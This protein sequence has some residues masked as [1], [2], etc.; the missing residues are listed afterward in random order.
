MDELAQRGLLLCRL[1]KGLIQAGREVE[2]RR[3]VG[4][5]IV[6]RVPEHQDQ[7]P[8]LAHSE[9]A[10]TLAS[11][12]LK[13][14]RHP[15]L[16]PGF[17]MLNAILLRYPRA[18]LPNGDLGSVLERDL[19]SGVVATFTILDGVLI[20]ENLVSRE[21]GKGFAAAA[22]DAIC[23]LADAEQCPIAGYVQANT[24]L[25]IPAGLAVDALHRWYARVGFKRGEIEPN[26]VLRR[27]RT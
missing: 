12:A 18:T 5:A 21:R 10:I 22:L 16:T 17:K 15:A 24:W 4:P 6:E 27:P 1:C 23:A 25:D 13:P 11:W 3:S 9:I 7:V 2:L 14:F 26:N 8:L 20:I 19:G